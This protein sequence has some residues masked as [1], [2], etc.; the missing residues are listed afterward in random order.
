M[1]LGKRYKSVGKKRFVI[2]GNP[3]P[4]VEKEL[5]ISLKQNSS[6]S[7][8]VG[9]INHKTGVIKLYYKASEKRG[10]IYENYC[11][12]AEVLEE[13]EGTS[14]IEYS[15]VFDFGIWVYT[16]VLALLCILIPIVSSLLAFF[17]YD[18]RTPLVFI[19]LAL[20]AAFGAFSFFVFKEKQSSVRPIIGEFEKLLV[21]T[22]EEKQ[23][24]AIAGDILYTTEKDEIDE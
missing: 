20:V 4:E 8:I 23:P 11:L 24:K 2:L 22:F 14:K 21:D 19:P 1:T 3:K 13:T 5:V 9:N 15:F 16:K 18:F 10:D 6:K 12:L 7:K 17:V